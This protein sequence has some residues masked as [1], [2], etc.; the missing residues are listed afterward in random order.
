MFYRKIVCLILDEK[1]NKKFKSYKISSFSNKISL[2]EL[3]NWC[4]D[5]L[6]KSE[7][8]S[9]V[10]ALENFKFLLGIVIWHNILLGLIW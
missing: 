6:L 9:L 1:P 7:I 4:D 3:Y 10:D 2:N 8:E 5:A